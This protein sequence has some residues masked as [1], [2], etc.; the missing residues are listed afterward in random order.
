MSY[1]STP[2]FPKT[3]MQL[4]NISTRQYQNS[5]QCLMKLVRC[6]GIRVLYIGF[7][8]NALRETVY[9]GTYFCCYKG[10]RAVFIQR[11]LPLQAA[12]PVAGGL[13][14]SIGWL[15]SF[16]LDCIRAW[17]KGQ[18]VSI[19]SRRVPRKNAVAICKSLLTQRGLIGLYSGVT[20]SIIRSYLVSG[21]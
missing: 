10:M 1:L 16:P 20:P 7:C 11:S 12:V 15:S 5:I 3:Q 13:A 8:V 9:L 17:V 14:G 6:Y 19:G 18:T 4:D 2:F 21:V